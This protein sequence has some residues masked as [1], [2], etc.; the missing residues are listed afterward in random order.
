VLL[1]EGLAEEH[2]WVPNSFTVSCRRRCAK[3]KNIEAVRVHSYGGP[4][5]LRFGDAPRPTP[6]SGELLIRVHTA[7]GILSTGK[8]EQAI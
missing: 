4:E 1:A 2:R 5:V 6:G 8:F 7:S 3:W